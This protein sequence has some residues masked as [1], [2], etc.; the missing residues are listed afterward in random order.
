MLFPIFTFP[1]RFP[2]LAVKTVSKSFKSLKPTR[3]SSHPAIPPFLPRDSLATLPAFRHPSVESRG[4]TCEHGRETCIQVESSTR[5]R[6]KC[7]TW[8]APHGN[9]F[10][11]DTQSSHRTRPSR[12]PPS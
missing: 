2:G 3:P 10:P 11:S 6:S 7:P 12:G 8:S 1:R 9:L 4:E 5:A